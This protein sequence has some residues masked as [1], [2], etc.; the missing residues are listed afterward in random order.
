MKIKTEIQNAFDKNQFLGVVSLDIEKA[1]DSTWRHRIVKKCKEILSNGHMLHFIELFL[2][3]ITF[4]VKI[5]KTL[6]NVF[7]Q[8]NGIPQGSNISTTLYLIAI[9]DITQNIKKPVLY[10]LFADDIN[11]LYRSKKQKTVKTFLLVMSDSR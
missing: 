4:Q 10:T 7:V 11:V 8:E 5:G 2:S 6:S 1:Y 9:N 3:K